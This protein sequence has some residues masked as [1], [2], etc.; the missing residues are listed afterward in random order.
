MTRAKSRESSFL[1]DA[2]I[3]SGQMYVRG[4]SGR[5]GRART[6]RKTLSRTWAMRG[7][8]EHFVN[9]SD[10]GWRERFIRLV[11]LVR[12]SLAIG[13]R[14][15]MAGV[16][17]DRRL[18]RADFVGAQPVDTWPLRRTRRAC[19]PRAENSLRPRKFSEKIFAPTVLALHSSSLASQLHPIKSM[20]KYILRRIFR[21]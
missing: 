6:F 2:Y 4:G 5:L 16:R 14:R 7:G 18:V 9:V 12:R 3:C 15:R 8:C 17:S 10:E 11:R 21:S 13:A 1:G 19:T 20:V